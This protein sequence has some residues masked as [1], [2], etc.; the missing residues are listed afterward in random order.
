MPPY[1]AL[2]GERSESLALSAIY[3]T[4]ASFRGRLR[5]SS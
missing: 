3:L 2:E 4:R 5:S 1:A